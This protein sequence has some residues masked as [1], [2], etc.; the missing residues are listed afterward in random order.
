MSALAFA[1][2]I[3]A[4]LLHAAWNLV[5]KKAGGD[6]RFVLLTA[7]MIVVVWLP[8]GLWA[9]WPAEGRAGL[10]GWGWREWG[11]VLASG[12]VHLAY[13]VTLLRGYRASDLTVVYP[14]ARGT[15]PLLSSVFAVLVLGEHLS[16][17]GGAGVLGVT[18]GVF[19]IAGGPG[20][21]KSLMGQSG[22][23][24][25]RARVK[26]GLLY[27]AA[28]GCLIAGY[29]VIDGYAVKYLLISPI[30]IDYFGNLLRIPF[31]LPQALRRRGHTWEAWRLQWRHAL[32]VALL[33]P[34]AYVLVLYATRLAPLSHVAPAREVSMLFAALIG[35]RLLGE[36]D[37]WLRLLGAAC[38]A[39]GV[40]ALALG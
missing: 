31:L 23:A 28:T 15:G 16:S 18:L 21:L 35:G 30:L 2:V 9:A 27:G 26:A 24:A 29:T 34:M 38:I 17:L 12:V 36:G 40:M 7:V 1:L 10:P 25:Q 19:L 14:V 5:A 22:D 3:V 6:N 39:V 11:F 4:A 33:S 8:V 13:F 20:L 32:V 37:R